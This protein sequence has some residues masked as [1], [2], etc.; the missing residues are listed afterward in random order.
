MVSI[1]ME[2]PDSPGGFT[3]QPGFGP[4]QPFRARPPSQRSCDFRQL[5]PTFVART[6]TC[7]EPERPSASGPGKV[8]VGRFELAGLVHTDLVE[9][10]ELAVVARHHRIVLD[11]AGLIGHDRNVGPSPLALQAYVRAA[12]PEVMPADALERQVHPVCDPPE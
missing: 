2:S 9:L 4:D 5:V 8:K 6:S 1:N 12:E 3:Q 7:G 11:D 10:R